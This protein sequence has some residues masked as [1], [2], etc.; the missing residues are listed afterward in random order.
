MTIWLRAF[1][2]FRTLGT[3]SATSARVTENKGFGRGG[4]AMSRPGMGGTLGW[5]R[6]CTNQTLLGVF[7]GLIFFCPQ[8]QKQRPYHTAYSFPTFPS[9]LRALPG[10]TH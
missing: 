2:S 5:G 1:I 9:A 7:L 6:F 10:S 8:K 4:A 3:A